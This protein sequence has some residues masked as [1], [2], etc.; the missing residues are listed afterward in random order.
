MQKN[1]NNNEK[2]FVLGHSIGVM[3]ST[4]YGID[5]KDDVDGIILSAGVT[6]DKAKLL[7]S[8]KDVD[9]DAEIPNALGNLICTDKRVLDDYEWVW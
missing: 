3:I 6:I 8:N 7:K 5:Y 1:K 2:V 9:D 4:V